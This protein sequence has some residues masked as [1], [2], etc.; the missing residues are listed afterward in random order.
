MRIRFEELA[1]R[2]RAGGIE[3]AV[4]ALA[5]SL[6]REGVSVSRSSESLVVVNRDVPDCIHFHGIW[7]PTLARRFLTWRRRGIPCVVSPHGMLEPWALAY[8][9][10]EKMLAWHVY[11][12]PILNRAAALHATSAREAENLRRLGLKATIEIIPWG[13]EIPEPRHYTAVSDANRS[14]RTALFVGRLH[15]IKGLPMLVE[16]WAK[17]R[18]GGWKMA[19]VGP[20]EAGHQ[21]EVQALVRKANLEAVFEFAGGLE[22]DSLQRSLPV[23]RS[24]HS[25]Q[26]HGKFRHGRRQGAVA[27]RAGNRHPRGA[28]GSAGYRGWRVVGAG[29][30]RRYCRGFGCCYCLLGG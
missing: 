10:L 15:P 19:P 6:K 23:C 27:W 16:A 13:L 22:G 14:H 7:S 26:S 4:R 1:A 18:P 5:E 9:P 20:D 28:V 30:D 8:K 24:L 11:Q 25:A 2:Q 12:R 3:A 17:V 29:I 21:A